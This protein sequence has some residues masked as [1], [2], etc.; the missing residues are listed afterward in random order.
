MMNEEERK[1]VNEFDYEYHKLLQFL[2]DKGDSK[3]DR[4]G[5]GTISH[6]GYQ[7]RFD[8]SK[9]FP[10][11]TTKKVFHRSIFHELI[12][13]LQ[14]STN[15]KYLVD[16]NVNIWN[17]W[18]FQF[19]LKAHNL[20]EEFPK[21]SDK[22]H[23]KLKEYV[24]NIKEDAEFAK[25][26]GELGPVYGKQWRDFN[27]VDQISRILKEIKETPHSRRIIVNAWN[28]AEIEEMQKSGLP[29][30]HTMF[31]FYVKDNKLSCQLYQRSADVFLGV[32]FNI[33]S[34]A[35]LTC[36]IAHVCDLE[37]GDF[38]HTFGDVH[39][40]NNHIEQV[41]EQLSRDSFK[42]CTLN[43]N[44]TTKNLFDIKF[45]DLEIKEYESHPPIKAPI[46]V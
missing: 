12:W 8:L 35:A 3:E 21:Y 39:I 19:Y 24:N 13:F 28:A 44:T 16:N 46:A 36:M 32:P 38:V 33:A 10:L 42:P 27:G 14:G 37:V 5:V 41:K 26:W 9:G 40:Y 30:C 20:E 4:T 15:I 6:F 31:Q 22:W 25:K 29:P 2:L 7:M 34:Y 17:E 23:E 1:Q 45:E 18:P 43:I 11:L